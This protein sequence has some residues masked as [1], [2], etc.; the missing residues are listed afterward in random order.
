MIKFV[1]FRASDIEP[2]PNEVLYWV[3]LNEDPT[4]G[5][6]KYWNEKGYWQTIRVLEGTLHEF[7]ERITK[8]VTE[9]LQEQTEWVEDQ[10]H[11]FDGRIAIVEGD[12]QNLYTVKQD[13]LIPG[14]GIEITEDNTINC[15]VDLSL[16]RVVAELPTEDI[17][18]SKI[19]I[20]FDP[21]GTGTNTHEEY[22]YVDGKWELLGKYA[23]YASITEL[24]Q[25]IADR[26]AADQLL[27]ES[28]TKE[29]S[30]RQS[31]IT[32]VEQ[33]INDESQIRQE[34]IAQTNQA[35]SEEVA[36]AIAAEEKLTQDL[37]AEIQRSTTTDETHTN[38]LSSLE[39][40]ATEL[41]EEIDAEVSRATAKETELNEAITNEISRATQKESE[42]ET[43]LDQFKSTKG[44]SS[45]LASLDENGRVPSS[46]LPE[47]VYSVVG[48]EVEVATKSEL[49][50]VEDIS[51][52]DRIYVLEDKKIYTKTTDGWNEGNTPIED[53]VYNFRR[54]DSQGRTNITKRWD[55][56]QMTVISET[57]SLG[58]TTGTAYE[59]S[60]GKANRD[61]LNSFPQY[62]VNVF[63][64]VSAG[65]STVELSNGQFITKSGIGYS[66]P[67]TLGARTIPAATTTTAGVMTA[68]DKAKLDA[69]EQN[70]IDATQEA[71]DYADELVDNIQVGGRN[72]ILKSDVPIVY[73]GTSNVAKTFNLS[74]KWNELSGKT[75]TISF[76]YTCENVS[77]GDIY[78]GKSRLGSETQIYN[79]LGER[80]LVSCWKTF[81]LNSSNINESKR[82]SFVIQ[83]PE[84]IVTDDSRIYFYIQLTGGN[85]SITNVKA[86][87]GNVSTDWTQAPEDL[88]LTF[89]D[90]TDGSFTVTKGT[91]EEQKVTIGKPATA[92]TAD[93]AN[94][95][96]SS[97][98]INPWFTIPGSVINTTT[99]QWVKLA[100]IPEQKKDFV[101]L[102]LVCKSDYNYPS[103]GSGTLSISSYTGTDK[104]TSSRSVSLRTNLVSYANNEG[105]IK[106]V[107]TK[108][109]Y[110]WVQITS[111]WEQ[112]NVGRILVRYSQ[113]NDNSIVIYTADQETST[114]QPENCSDVIEY[115]G[116]VRWISSSPDNFTYHS[117]EYKGNTNIVKKT[118]DTM[119]GRLTVETA[120]ITP[121]AVDSSNENQTALLVKN[122]QSTKLGLGWHKSWGSYLYD[123]N[124]DKYI[125][126]KSD[127]LYWNNTN[128]FYHTG[129][130]SP[131]TTNT[132]QTITAEKKFVTT[133]N[134]AT[135]Y[136]GNGI[137]MYQND[138][139]HAGGITWVN[140]DSFESTD[141]YNIGGIGAYGTSKDEISYFYIGHGTM[142]W[143]AEKSLLIY[144]TEMRFLNNKVWHAGNDGSGSGLD[145]DTVDGIHASS[146]ALTTSKL[147]NPYALT[148]TGA[149]TGTYDGSAAKTVNIP[150]ASTRASLG[151]NTTDAVVFAKVTASGGFWKESD[152]RLKSNIKPL[153]HTIEQIT[154]IPTVEFDMNDKHQIGT[155]AQDIETVVPEVVSE[156]DG[157]KK[158]E[159][160][161][162]GVLAIE[163][164]K[165]LKQEIEDLKKEIELL[166]NK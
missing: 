19:Y 52:G 67:S 96:P 114:E 11:Q 84:N 109:G 22:V 111:V 165:L 46:Q 34:S 156:S 49:D 138:P 85:A 56:S 106:F 64:T 107:L 125:N 54:A 83:I 154:S 24:Q 57:V 108:D 80:T 120:D 86:E 27:Q 4:G 135:Y 76:D 143:S 33:L 20:V 65:S 134:R 157:I 141:S 122:Q 31:E 150:A 93:I 40:K 78:I 45:G 2:N 37:N 41:E 13:K 151:L 21:D 129:N 161:M 139:S 70:V 75:I 3:D 113:Y 137:K 127:N 29:I 28:I 51:E 149:A 163:G 95:M 61:A 50:T 98:S 47:S 100:Y 79:D 162:M 69:V 32:R 9:E 5:S 88:E 118:G 119:T 63:P 68:A 147:A 130:L 144:P 66:Q 18:E 53:V 77:T 39:T 62:L 103:I 17:D 117:I 142:P 23:D 148:F 145:A 25:E 60:K 146:F 14:Y 140:K 73:G 10:V 97:F 74:K 102:Q 136:T 90:G 160:S 71:K 30:D 92:G 59:G 82:L 89:T 1:N 55:G 42:I 58:E 38:K 126:F 123:Y 7:E 8:W 121:L 166:K 124:T 16:Y 94:S 112:Y 105:S 99:K 26:K 48:I 6:I 15:T 91:G 155:I 158:V 81:T 132:Q 72:L 159:Y 128:G 44:Q 133:V 101:L 110:L 36:R 115:N 12:I 152:K 153:Q 164:I 87:L 43:S 35:I 131:V 104:V 116:G